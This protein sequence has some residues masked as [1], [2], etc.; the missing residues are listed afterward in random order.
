MGFRV[1]RM[2]GLECVHGVLGA[3]RLLALIGL[4]AS[5]TGPG[6]LKPS[7]LNNELLTT[8]TLTLHPKLR[9]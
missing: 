8:F 7:T 6:T 1:F 3:C 2:Q 9:A 4:L 5:E